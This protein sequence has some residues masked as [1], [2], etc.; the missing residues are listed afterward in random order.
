VSSPGGWGND[1]DDGQS[2]LVDKLY[3]G[4]MEQTDH[5][6]AELHDASVGK[7][8]LLHASVHGGIPS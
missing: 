1:G 6:S 8:R 4:V 7:R 2:E 3:A 5:L